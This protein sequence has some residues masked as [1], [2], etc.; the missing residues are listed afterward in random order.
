MTLSAREGAWSW[1]QVSLILTQMMR[2]TEG[3]TGDLSRKGGVTEEEPALGKR[4][5]DEPAKSGL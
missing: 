1:S 2:A 5:V 3:R 4:L